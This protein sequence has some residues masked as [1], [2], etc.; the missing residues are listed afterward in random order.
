MAPRTRGYFDAER[1]PY[2]DAPRVTL[3]RLGVSADID[4]LVDTGAS[5][6][7]IHWS[8]RS[9]FATPA[10]EPLA[11]AETFAS[12]FEMYGIADE[13]VWY[14][15]EEAV[16]LFPTD[17]GGRRPVEI[18]VCIALAPDGQARGGAGIPS[19]LG[20]DVLAEARLDFYLP[21]G[22]LTLEWER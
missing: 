9:R 16:L 18:T 8:D 20:R 4:F 15:V 21:G 5:R 14:G 10:G 2:A 3:P 6:T 22:E 19:L 1:Q 7:A 12:Q 13:G 17:R 11:E